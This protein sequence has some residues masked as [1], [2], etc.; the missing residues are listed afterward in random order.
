MASKKRRTLVQAL[1]D[2]KALQQRRNV[3]KARISWAKRNALAPTEA[4]QAKT[5]YRNAMS[6]Q[7]ERAEALTHRYV[8]GALPV[9]GSGDLLSIA[10]LSRGI[11]AVRLHLDA[12]AAGPAFRKA[13]GVAFDRATQHARVNAA[14]VMRLKLPPV[15]KETHARAREAFVNRQVMLR[16]RA[17]AA[18]SDAFHKAIRQ[19]EEGTSLREALLHQLW[20]TRERGKLIADN[21]VAK[22]TR[23]EFER[24]ADEM[25]SEEFVYHTCKDERV[26]PTHAA[27]DGKTFARGQRPPQLDE[28]NCRCWLIPKE[29]LLE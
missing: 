29:A 3:A 12:L 11:D 7:L 20:V 18:Q 13:A 14:R 19:Y 10:D 23:Y 22:T 28:V 9:L 2:T 6:R 24:W 1:E 15:D 8:I 16:Q 17:N 27:L 26:R 21:E 5:A 25:G 4:T